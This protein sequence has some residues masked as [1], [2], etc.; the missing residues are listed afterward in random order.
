MP[1][2]SILLAAA[3]ALVLT[4]NPPA[5]AQRDTSG[6]VMSLSQ[7]HDIEPHEF[8]LNIVDLP[9]VALMRA[10]RRIRDSKANQERLRFDDRMGFVFIEHFPSGGYGQNTVDLLNSVAFTRKYAEGYWKR[11]VPVEPFSVEEERKIYAFRE[12]GGRLLAT[13]GKN[14]GTLCIVARLGF[15]SD[16]HKFGAALRDIYDTALSM[17]DC[18]GKRSLDDVVKWLEGVKIV[19]PPYNRVR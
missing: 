2:L 16:E 12:R 17:Y 10:Q 1:R 7:W 8:S 13:R 6:K 15:L 5:F 9:G 18:S 3:L 4:S 19:E 14:S 11:R